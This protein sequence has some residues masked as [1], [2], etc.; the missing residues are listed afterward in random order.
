MHPTP[1]PLPS[2]YTGRDMLLLIGAVVGPLI[3]SVLYIVASGE[4]N[5]ASPLDADARASRDMPIFWT[6]AAFLLAFVVVGTWW[7]SR[8]AT[9]LLFALLSFSVSLAAM[10]LAYSSRM[11]P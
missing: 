8:P 6:Y 3:I 5:R 4:I 11:A 2:P 1:D 10:F 9:K 7:V